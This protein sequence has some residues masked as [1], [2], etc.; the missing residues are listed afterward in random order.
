MKH[1]IDNV[2]ETDGARAGDGRHGLHGFALAVRLSVL[3]SDH[4]VPEQHAKR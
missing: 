3:E 2:I 4:G 1:T